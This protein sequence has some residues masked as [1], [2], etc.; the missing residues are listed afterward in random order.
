MQRDQVMVRCDVCGKQ[1]TVRKEDALSWRFNLP[2]Y[3]ALDVT[4][5]IT[6]IETCQVDLCLDCL[7]KVILLKRIDKTRE[8][9]AGHD[10]T[11]PVR[12]GVKTYEFIKE[13]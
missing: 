9:W 1:F 8:E 12:T 6:S 3:T 4:P 10:G 5:D 2:M 13:E 7:K 11:R